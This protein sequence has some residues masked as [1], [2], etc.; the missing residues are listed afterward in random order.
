M[1]TAELNNTEL[2]AVVAPI[3]DAKELEK[4]ARKEALKQARKEGNEIKSFAFEIKQDGFAYGYQLAGKAKDFNFC[5]SDI[6]RNITGK[7]YALLLIRKT[8]GQKCGISLSKDF[9]FS[10]TMGNRTI[11]T[12]QVQEQLNIKLKIGYKAERRRQFETV[13]S[14]IIDEVLR[15]NNLYTEA[16]ISQLNASLTA[17]LPA[18]AN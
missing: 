7:L 11:N 2:T 14:L 13:L 1:N 6:V 18:Q 5:T 4:Q 12:I 9:N 16:E 8:T 17:L 3:Q 10:F 15:G